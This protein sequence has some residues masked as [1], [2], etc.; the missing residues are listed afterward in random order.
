VA[1]SAPRPKEFLLSGPKLLQL[2]RGGDLNRSDLCGQRQ[3][4]LW[5]R[6]CRLR[7]L[8]NPTSHDN[9]HDSQERG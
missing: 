3:I 8:L 5:Q 7:S 4:T 9:D 2:H 6:V 1:E